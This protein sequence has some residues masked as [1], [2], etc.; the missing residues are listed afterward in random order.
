MAASA[1]RH[2]RVTIPAPV[3]QWCVGAGESFATSRAPQGG[4]RSFSYGRFNPD[5][6]GR[7][8]RGEALLTTVW[9]EQD[10][11][12]AL[13]AAH[14]ELHDELIGSPWPQWYVLYTR[15]HCE[16]LVYGQLRAKHFELFLPTLEVWSRRGG[17]RRRISVPMFPG[18]LFL[19][20]ALDKA[21]FLEVRKVRGLVRILGERWDRLAAVPEVEIGAIQAVVRAHVP[22]QPHSYLREGQRVRIARGPL[23]GVEGILLQVKSTKG[24]LLL[25]VE[26]LRRS[27]T[28]EVDCTTVVAA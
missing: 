5:D 18:Y 12:G 17:L 28:V 26:L 20:H 1:C 16:H 2:Q 6:E 14:D 8:E 22:A 11:P 15:S 4:T 24:V 3:R 27:V 10:P 7:T 13:S 21:S 23:A 25:S 19:H 9:S